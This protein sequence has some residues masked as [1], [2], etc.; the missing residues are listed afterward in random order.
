MKSYLC[1]A[2]EIAVGQIF[3]LAW[4][5][6]SLQY[7]IIPVRIVTCVL[8]HATEGIPF[9]VQPVSQEWVEDMSV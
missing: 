2:A 4:S 6:L 9:L 7:I 5:P 1:S 3:H 8:L